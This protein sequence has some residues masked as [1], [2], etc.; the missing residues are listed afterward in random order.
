[1]TCFVDFRNPTSA[2]CEKQI[3]T[4]LARNGHQH[5]RTGSS[6]EP[7]VV[8]SQIPSLCSQ[9]SI[10]PTPTSFRHRP[11]LQSHIYVHNRTVKKLTG[12]VQTLS[13]QPHW[14]MHKEFQIKNNK[15]KKTLTLL[16]ITVFCTDNRA[17]S[18]R[19]SDGT[20]LRLN[21]R[22]YAKESAKIISGRR[23]RN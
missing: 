11:S 20:E 16:D 23:R 17:V 18:L 2:H 19:P 4:V 5:L 1:M 22:V 8:E 15:N 6:K 12:P 14:T 9:R 3:N 10:P 7:A 21:L 13:S